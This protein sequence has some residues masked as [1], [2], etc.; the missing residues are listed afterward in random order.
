MKRINE[1]GHLGGQNNFPVESFAQKVIR[2]LEKAKEQTKSSILNML[3]F[4]M[5]NFIQHSTGSPCH[6]NQTIKINK[7]N[8]N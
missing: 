2:G 1:K 6:N 7:R 5:A 4:E 3:K 8:P